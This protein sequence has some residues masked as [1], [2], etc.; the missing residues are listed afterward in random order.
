MFTPLPT[1]ELEQLKCVAC[2]EEFGCGANAS[3][4]D[5]TLNC[6]CSAIE[7]SEEALAEM[8]SRFQGCLCRNC[9]TKFNV[10]ERA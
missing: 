2:G 7:I 10:D 6:W 9:L 8:Q 4:G 3:A 1:P 5:T